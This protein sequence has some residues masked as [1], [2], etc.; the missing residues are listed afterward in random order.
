M[1]WKEGER[2]SARGGIASKSRQPALQET[3]HEDQNAVLSLGN[4]VESTHLAKQDMKV[5]QD[6]SGAV[7]CHTS[8]QWVS[9][10]HYRWFRAALSLGMAAFGMLRTEAA[11]REAWIHRHRN[12]VVNAE[13]S[14]VKIACDSLGNIIVTGTSDRSFSGKETV[15]IK[16]S[17]TTG[18]QLWRRTD[19]PAGVKDLAIDSCDNVVLTGDAG[20]V[21]RLPDGTAIWTNSFCGSAMAVDR[22]G[23][24]VLIGSFE[25]SAYAVKCDTTSG[26]LLWRQHFGDPEGADDQPLAVALDDAGNVVVA[27]SSRT[28]T[29]TSL[30]IVRYR[31][32]D[33]TVLWEQHSFGGSSVALDGG[34]NVLGIRSPVQ[35]SYAYHPS[36]LAA[37][38]G[39]VLWS[40]LEWG[41]EYPRIVLTGSAESDMLAIWNSTGW[42]IAH[43]VTA[44]FAAND[45]QLLWLHNSLNTEQ[46]VA[47]CEAAAVDTMGNLI[48]IG[49]WRNLSNRELYTAKYAAANGEL[50]WEKSTSRPGVHSDLCQALAI[51][52]DGNI[53][54]AGSWQSAGGD[55]DIYTAKYAAV[56]GSLLWEQR[57]NSLAIGYAD[58]STAT[59]DPSG[60]VIVAGVA[61]G[62]SG[63]APVPYAARHVA[64]DGALLWEKTLDLTAAV[65]SITVAI[66]STGDMVMS[67]STLSGSQFAGFTAKFAGTDGTLLW[68]N[69]HETMPQSVGVDRHGQVA[70]TGVVFHQNYADYVTAK[71]AA[72]DGALLWEKRYNGPANQHDFPVATV[73]DYAGNVVVT[74]KS[75]DQFVPSSSIGAAGNDTFDF[76]TIKYASE[77]GAPLWEKRFDGPGDIQNDEAT[78][79]A[80]DANDNVIVTGVSA[81]WSFTKT[82]DVLIDGDYYTAKYAA[83]DGALLWERRY[84]SPAKAWDRP[85]AMA[86]DRQGNV[87]VTG[88]SDNQPYTAKYAG[89]DGTVLWEQRYS[90]SGNLAESRALAVDA[91]N[92][93]VV[94]GFLN[95][96]GGDFDFLTVKYAGSDGTLLWEARYASPTNGYDAVHSSRGLALGPNGMVVVTGP[97]FPDSAT[98]VYQEALLSLAIA[99]SPGGVRLGFTGIPGQT[100]GLERAPLVTGPWGRVATLTA[101]PDGSLVYVDTAPPEGTVFYRSCQP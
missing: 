34:G 70:V 78:A 90:A 31:A 47:L 81:K 59:V 60:S 65:E 85:S 24:V 89:T 17:G 39:S 68:T 86:V 77:D 51:D 56:D 48:V 33:G 43:I 53:V 46:R 13:D 69:L 49:S 42:D 76:Y 63:A 19:S 95:K 55:H 92:D 40:N 50:L 14:A 80:V 45:G 30:Y 21:K 62:A 79:L 2:S 97:S 20:T 4:L 8:I 84:G 75:F 36:K 38:D 82:G 54:V 23:N 44:K 88:S 27:G 7:L 96:G 29:N 3:N 25:G 73:V 98:V 99:I 87:V 16:Y 74:G 18:A 101:S 94:T 93:V 91:H 26:A 71:F 12:V 28:E 41:G 15:T 72:S 11:V 5:I 22:S 83:A 37:A 32:V 100:Y 57:Y 67:G 9:D 61:Y 66:D 35:G 58:I 1:L 10:R 6:F 52:R 64:A